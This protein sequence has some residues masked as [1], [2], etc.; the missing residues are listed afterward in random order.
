MPF[1]SLN[2]IDAESIIIKI[3]E[4]SSLQFNTIL[5]KNLVR[6]FLGYQEVSV[7]FFYS[8]YIKLRF[9]LAEHLN[10]YPDALEK[11]N[12]VAKVKVLHLF[13]AFYY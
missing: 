11:Y 8:L 1:D 12:F 6:Y 9:L 13:N 4:I 2:N 7:L 10:Q 3:D 5:F